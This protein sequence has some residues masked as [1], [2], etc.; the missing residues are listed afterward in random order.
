MP[1]LVRS[2]DMDN[3]RTS[4]LKSEFIFVRK[5]HNSGI[6]ARCREN[7]SCEPRCQ[8]AVASVRD[9]KDFELGSGADTL[10]MSSTAERP[11]LLGGRIRL[12][13]ETFLDDRFDDNCSPARLRSTSLPVTPN[14]RVRNS[15]DVTPRRRSS[16]KPTK[17]TT[18]VQR[19]CIST[20]RRNCLLAGRLGHR[21]F[22]MR[23]VPSG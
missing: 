7:P 3:D 9:V 22:A 19:R 23:N 15:M 5:S 20:V 8:F 6:Y 12:H 18:A 13:Q 4:A 17:L 21:A 1:F 2:I 14:H 10:R 16:R 11:V